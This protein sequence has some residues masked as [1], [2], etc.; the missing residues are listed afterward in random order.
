MYREVLEGDGKWRGA[1]VGGGGLGGFFDELFGWTLLHDFRL[2]H[3]KSKF[4]I[5][6]REAGRPGFGAQLPVCVKLYF[7]DPRYSLVLT[8]E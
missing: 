3:K 7:K 2:D 1:S 5:S 6:T 8:E 4:K